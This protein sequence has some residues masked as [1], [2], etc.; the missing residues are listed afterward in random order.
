[1]QD[2]K[3]KMISILE[4]EEQGLTSILASIMA[5]RIEVINLLR[6][7]SQEIKRDPEQIKKLAKQRGLNDDFIRA[8]LHIIDNE[9]C[10]KPPVE[11]PSKDKSKDRREFFRNNLLE[12]TRK[13]AYHYNDLYNVDAPFATSLYL[14]FEKEVLSK[15]IRD[16]ELVGVKGTAVDLGCA[17][18]RM[19]LMIA[20]DFKSFNKIQGFDISP[21]MI[22]AAD[23][24]KTRGANM[25]LCQ[26][27]MFENIDIENGIPIE[28]GTA[29]LVVMNLG[30]ASDIYDIE[31]LISRIRKIL[32]KDG[33]F[34]LSFYNAGRIYYQLSIPWS[35]SLTAEIDPD[36]H[37]LNIHTDGE[38]HLV[39][40]RPYT[41]REVKKLFQRYK[42]LK[43]SE[44]STFPTMAS[45]LPDEFFIEEKSKSAIEE[46]DRNLA[47][48]EKGAYILVSGRK[49]S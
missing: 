39:Y 16:L 10:A 21:I 8:M 26:H 7:N 29:S 34:L 47:G 35:S 33:R 18:G 25:T 31:A 43:I 4:K 24:Q 17:N 9:P 42:D 22:Q 27:V 44:I 19:S 48:M 46:I 3:E 5:K 6:N 1:M 14:K 30:T 40:A 41:V 15:T 12:F 20:R 45:I 49:D 37:C 13:I 11:I 23:G 38:D 28:E 2:E 32:M 36:N